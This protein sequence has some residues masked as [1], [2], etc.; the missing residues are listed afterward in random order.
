MPKRTVVGAGLSG[1]V[2]AIDLARQG[3]EVLVLGKEKAIGG[4]PAY[5]PSLHATP[6]DFQYTS[7]EASPLSTS[8]SSSFIAFPVSPLAAAA[9]AKPFNPK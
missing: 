7:A 3:D 4:S 8:R 5:H 6:I 9:S 2:A 1:M